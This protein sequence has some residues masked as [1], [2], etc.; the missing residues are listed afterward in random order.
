M[1]NLRSE[2]VSRCGKAARTRSDELC[3]K[4]MNHERIMRGCFAH[5]AHSVR[6]AQKECQKCGVERARERVRA[7][8]GSTKAVAFPPPMRA[9]TR[10][11]RE[12]RAHQ[13]GAA[14]SAALFGEGA[15]R[16][17]VEATR[18]DKRRGR[19]TKNLKCARKRATSAFW[20]GDPRARAAWKRCAE[21]KRCNASR[22][23]ASLWE[24]NPRKS[25]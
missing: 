19:A 11:R 12:Q 3:E 18:E 6:N 8:P 25:Q 22:V 13:G 5:F 14:L 1:L 9:S 21:M 10:R 20:T 2:R 16:V 7:Q 15:N 17:V 23:R 24:S 4:L